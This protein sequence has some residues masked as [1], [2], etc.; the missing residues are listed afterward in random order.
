MLVD[1]VF[2]LDYVMEVVLLIM[3]AE[4]FFYRKTITRRQRIFTI[5]LYY[6][7][8]ILLM[9]ILTKSELFIKNVNLTLIKEVVFCLAFAALIKLLYKATY[10]RTVIIGA[11]YIAIQCFGEFISMI[12][13][14]GYISKLIPVINA[15]MQNKS[16]V[17][18]LLKLVFDF[19]LLVFFRYGRGKYSESV[20]TYK[21][22]EWIGLFIASVLP[23]R[24]MLWAAEEGDIVNNRAN[25]TMFF[26]MVIIIAITNYF[27]FWLFSEMAK[28]NQRIKQEE[29]LSMRLQNEVMSYQS[30]AEN[31]EQ[32]QRV[33]HEYKHNL[34]AIAMLAEQGNIS[35]LKEVTGKAVVN[36]KSS[37]VISTKH[38]IVDAIL[39]TKYQEAED[40][41]IGL[42]MK[43]DD[44]SQLCLDESDLIIILSNLLNNAIDAAEESVEKIIKM[45][46]VIENDKVILS[47][48]NSHSADIVEREGVFASSKEN[49]NKDHGY[50]IENVKE[51]VDKYG[52]RY[53]IDYD[54][55]YFSFSIMI[56]N[57][58]A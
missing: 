12:L 4:M 34:A 17:Y 25:D 42:L 16:I 5:L 54:E 14:W 1:I 11:F 15:N 2:V 50:G 36:L 24:F 33:A 20:G 37:K 45:K 48:K 35:A 30:L 22:Q 31:L 49:Q 40:K 13:G 39:N 9:T 58:R 21:K 51:C 27:I 55:E 26:Y 47:V 43:I 57:I 46:F 53:V 7:F 56:E 3:F 29:A 6:I 32:Q 52:G 23:L 44:L 8:H 18:A 10:I 41:G 28:R 19:I 38:P